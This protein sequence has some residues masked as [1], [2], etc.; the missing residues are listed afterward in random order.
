VHDRVNDKMRDWHTRWPSNYRQYANTD[1]VD[2]TMWWDGLI[3]DGWEPA[4]RPF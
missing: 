4:T 3:F 1:K 2:G